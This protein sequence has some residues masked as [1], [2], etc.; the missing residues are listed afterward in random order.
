MRFVLLGLLSA[1]LLSSA[2]VAFA[3]DNQETPDSVWRGP[4]W[5]WYQGDAFGPALAGDQKPGE[6]TQS[7][8]ATETD[9][10][11]H[12]QETCIYVGSDPLANGPR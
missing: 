3:K 2:G 7:P 12:W 1:G 8:F 6:K 5:Y 4:G 9:C 11:Q 10:E